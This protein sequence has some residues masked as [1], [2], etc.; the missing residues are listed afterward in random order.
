MGVGGQRHAPTALPPGKNLYPLY[1]RLGEPQGLF[2]RVRKI[3]PPTGIRSPGRPARS[4]SIY[5]LNYSSPFSFL[6]YKFK[7]PRPRANAP[8]WHEPTQ[9]VRYIVTDKQEN[10]CYVHGSLPSAH[11]PLCKRDIVPPYLHYY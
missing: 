1:R 9:H 3:S 2:G 10:P 5:R 8:H 11:T 7:E 4:E 6:T